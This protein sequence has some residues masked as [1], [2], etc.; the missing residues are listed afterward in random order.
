MSLS[1]PLKN[2]PALPLTKRERDLE[3]MRQYSE[4]D[5]LDMIR[6]HLA[7]PMH[8]RTHFLRKQLPNGGSAL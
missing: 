3:L 1:K 5:M 2:K 8:K 4:Q 7:L 6:A